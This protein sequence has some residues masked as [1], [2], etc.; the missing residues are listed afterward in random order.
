M[1]RRFVGRN[2]TGSFPHEEFLS[3]RATV[4]AY[5]DFCKEHG[6]EKT[7]RSVERFAME[8]TAGDTKTYNGMNEQQIGDV[9]KDEISRV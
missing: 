9:L 7:L 1:A 5:A 4:A 3:K 6:V 8:V 2:K